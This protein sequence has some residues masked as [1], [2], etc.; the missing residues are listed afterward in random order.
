MK[1]ILCIGFLSVT[2][3]GQSQQ[4][5]PLSEPDPG[6]FQ[7]VQVILIAEDSLS[8]SFLIWVK[9][10][11]AEH[12]HAYHTENVI[13]LEGTATLT[14]NERNFTI[15]PGDHIFIPAGTRHSV[16]VKGPEV[17]KVISIQSPRFDG[18][19]RIGTKSGTY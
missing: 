7:N 10:G 6:E 9:Q 12:Y 13:V 19:D 16:T 3:C 15:R 1:T 4:H 2:L 14:L 11:V 8:S 5:L 17:L 18:T